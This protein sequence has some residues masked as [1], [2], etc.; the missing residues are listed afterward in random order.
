MRRSAN[1]LALSVAA[2]TG[3]AVLA[4]SASATAASGQSASRTVRLTIH[5][6][7][8]NGHSEQI[9]NGNYAEYGQ[10]V[11]GSLASGANYLGVGR[12][13]IGVEVPTLD[14]Q[15]NDIANTLIARNV[16]VQHNMTLTLS[17]IKSV[18]VQVSLNGVQQ[19]SVMGNVCA[20]TLGFPYPLIETV[21]SPP[22]LYIVP[23]RSKTLSFVYQATSATAGGTEI[24]LGGSFA[25]LPAKPV[26]SFTSAGL[27]KVNLRVAAGA[28][29]PWSGNAGSFSFSISAGGAVCEA[30]QTYPPASVL[31]PS[32]TTEYFSPGTWNPTYIPNPSGGG[33]TI[34]TLTQTYAAGRSYNST[35]YGA[36][37]G[38]DFSTPVDLPVAGEDSMA[39]TAGLSNV[40]ADPAGEAYDPDGRALVSLTWHRRTLA[41]LQLRHLVEPYFRHVIHHSGWYTLA[42][43]ATRRLANNAQLLSPQLTVHWR[44]YVSVLQLDLYP[45]L[46]YTQYRVGGLN[47]ANQAAPGTRTTI[48]VS[49]VGP[50][51]APNN[52]RAWR[53]VKMQVSYNGG[54]TWQTLRL[55]RR[56]R[57]WTLT[58]REPVSGDVSLRSTVVST[59][60]DS[61]VQTIYDAYGIG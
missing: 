27:A 25:G 28:V 12:Y 50:T 23:Y 33:V 37:F 24:N 19:S 45:Q 55:I 36:A 11:E 56:G 52:G 10:T 1:V 59:N 51:G 5:A 40:F 53:E 13:A 29:R 26:A 35:F 21:Q 32:V 42:I 58:F 8:Q 9:V 43:D 34:D 54:S 48:A 18:P 44:F 17:A 22:P 14:S 30:T 3:V 39:I 57:A 2:V 38:P 7:D 15:G 41:R 60:G 49:V 16:N 20:S 46:S 6:I 61:S 4:G 31:D 47:L